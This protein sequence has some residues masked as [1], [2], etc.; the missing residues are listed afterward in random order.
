MNP[1]SPQIKEMTEKETACY[2]KSQ[3]LLER[4][5][6]VVKV[7]YE[8]IEL[9]GYFYIAPNTEETAPTLIVHQ[10]K[11]AWAEDCKYYADEAMRRGYNCLLIDGP[12]NGQALRRHDLPF[13]PDW[14][15]FITP[16]IYYL[17]TRPEVNQKELILTGMSMGG[18]LAPRAAAFE[19]R[20]R[21]SVANPG[22][23]NWGELFI[24]R[25]N[26]YSPQLMSMYRNSPELM[27]SIIDVMEFLNPFLMWGLTDTMW[28]HG[29]KTP[30]QMLDEMQTYTNKNTA[31]NITAAM[32]IINAEYE[33]YGQARQ[34]YDTIPGKKDFMVFTEEE[35]APLHVQTGSLA[36]S[37]SRIF[38]WIDEELDRL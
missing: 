23:L 29:A 37:I 11:D 34:L 15:T 9:T 35:A 28:K 10:G 19:N 36:V 30:K 16:V 14:E 7:P 4:P 5:M 21:A 12:G 31:A 25:I 17:E 33:P 27:N 26:E 6:E 32:L 3:K 24:E 20:L 38:D 18:F 1:E 2:I 13:H 8:G 22:V